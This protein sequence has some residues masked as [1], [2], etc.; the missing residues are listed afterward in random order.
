[1][2]EINWIAVAFIVLPHTGGLAGGIITKK[3]IF[4]YNGLKKPFGTPPGWS[5]SPI[6]TILYSSMGYASYMV[7]RDGYGFDGPAGLPLLIYAINLLVNWTWTPMFFARKDMK[8]ALYNMQLINATALCM[9]YLFYKINS[10]AGF[11]IIPYL[12]WLVISTYLNYTFM[13]K[14]PPKSAIN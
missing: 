3:N 11:L 7:Y 10:T 5:F 1:M 13:I 4:W 9:A 6:W 2:Q 8:L 14:N 12:A